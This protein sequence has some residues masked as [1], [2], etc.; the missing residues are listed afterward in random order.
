MPR[1]AQQKKRLTVEQERQLNQRVA[2]RLAQEMAETHKGQWIGLIQGEV[3]AMASTLET[4]LEKMSAT[5]PDPSRGLV[6]QAG[7]DYTKKK[8]ILS[9]EG[10]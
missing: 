5:E 6:F 2:R 10:R 7:K 8:I 1:R 9:V 4:V 3:V